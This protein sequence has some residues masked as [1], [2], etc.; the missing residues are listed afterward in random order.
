MG[1]VKQETRNDGRGL[2]HFDYITF[3]EPRVV[4]ILIEKRSQL[5]PAYLP[6]LEQVPCIETT[7][8]FLTGDPVLNTYIDL[9]ILLD[10]A[11]L[12]KTE[13]FIAKRLM[14]GYTIQDIAEMHNVAKSTVSTLYGRLVQ[15]VV[16]E[17]N[18]RWMAVYAVKP[19][20]EK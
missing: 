16:D 14:V 8:V 10:A 7:G 15:K 11:G 6:C 9:D 12:T 20:A 18:R 19:D 1:S 4:K 2:R 13:R 5:D 3:S 17:N